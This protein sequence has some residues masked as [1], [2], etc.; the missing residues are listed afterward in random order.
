[1]FFGYRNRKQDVQMRLADRAVQSQA[2]Q[3]G[4]FGASRDAV[5]ESEAQ[6]GLE[7]RLASL[8]ATGMS[9]AFQNCTANG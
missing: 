4:A 3:A 1:M 9:Q 6:R 8:R 5:M 2:V 7:D